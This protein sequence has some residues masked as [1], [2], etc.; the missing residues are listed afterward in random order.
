VKRAR[1]SASSS[2][3][4]TFR[5][6]RESLLRLRIFPFP[7]SS[8]ST[9]QLLA[10][11]IFTSQSTRSHRYT[12]T[13]S[14]RKRFQ[15]SATIHIVGSTNE[16]MSSKRTA[17]A[18]A[19]DGE[20][21]RRSP[22][23]RKLTSQSSTLPSFTAISGPSR[24]E[25]IMWSLKRPRFD[26]STPILHSVDITQTV[27]PPTEQ[28]SKG[29]QPQ[30]LYNPSS[31]PF[32]M[33]S[34][35]ATQTASPPDSQPS[36]EDKPQRVY[37]PTGRQADQYPRLPFPDGLSFDRLFGSA[38]VP[39]KRSTTPDARLA[40]SQHSPEDQVELFQSLPA[41]GQP[42]EQS[43]KFSAY[44]ENLGAETSSI[45]DTASYD[46]SV[47]P[48]GTPS[49]LRAET[50]GRN[51]SILA[52]I[53]SQPSRDLIDLMPGISEISPE[54]SQILPPKY[55][56]NHP[57]GVG[58]GQ[59]GWNDEHK[60]AAGFT[61]ALPPDHET[62]RWE[63]GTERAMNPARYHMGPPLKPFDTPRVE[64]MAVEQQRLLEKRQALEK[65][66]SYVQDLA[67]FDR[68]FEQRQAGLERQQG[69][70]ERHA[71]LIR[72][73]GGRRWMDVLRLPEH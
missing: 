7:S 19:D 27:S 33:T 41:R 66:Q 12:T 4:H 21:E 55:E 47:T 60:C 57:F 71:D 37:T 28:Q 49:A 25:D 52:P 54:T 45:S 67:A 65:Q 14:R 64:E 6:Q 58:H 32:S 5:T 43:Q 23:M 20:P 34:S 30:S 2:T 9:S 15:R 51:H 70:G 24:P 63:D 3:L 26:S 31:E 50:R 44:R 16:N 73:E 1:A 13:Q 61:C 29:D 72:A 42:T 56:P 62:R 36:P 46:E 48:T 11:N 69:F 22:E 35:P 53:H 68:H 18:M 17:S 40:I 39:R 38:A 59:H 10:L 8:S